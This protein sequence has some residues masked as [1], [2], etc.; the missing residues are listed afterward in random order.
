MCYRY[1]ACVRRFH[2]LMLIIHRIFDPQNNMISMK[3]LKCII[4]LSFLTT[5]IFAQ[6][7][8]RAA[9]FADFKGTISGRVMH[10]EN[11]EGIEYANVVLYR[12]RDSSM[13]TGTITDKNGQFLME[14]VPI[15]K[16]Y[17]V[18]NFIG[19][20][21]SVVG[22]VLMTPRQPNV[23]IDPISLKVAVT[24]LEGAEI[25]GNKSLL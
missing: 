21:K 25:V 16:F 10:A 22:D 3:T 18:A 14:E 20:E 12:L 8:S 24:E 2:F 17:L 11:N 13:V 6:P 15:G 9:A 7:G 19:Y 1:N 5:S 4:V 23:T